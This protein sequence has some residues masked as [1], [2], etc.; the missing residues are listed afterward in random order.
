MSCKECN[1][2]QNE[3]TS[4]SFFRWGAANIEVRACKKHL[5]E[6]YDVLRAH[7]KSIQEAKERAYPEPNK[8]E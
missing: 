2:I 4:T 8:E 6:I 7:Q 5:K 3:T 1:Y